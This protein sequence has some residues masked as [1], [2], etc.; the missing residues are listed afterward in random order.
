MGKTL[1]VLDELL[2][3]VKPHI[4][5]PGRKVNCEATDHIAES[6]ATYLQQALQPES[7]L[8]VPDGDEVEMEIEA[9]DLV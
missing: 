9:N 5:E 1:Q 2:Q 6:M 7:E 3:H 8:V 4:F